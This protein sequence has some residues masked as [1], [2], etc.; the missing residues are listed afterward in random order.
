MIALLIAS[1]IDRL[2]STIPVVAFLDQEEDTFKYWLGGELLTG[3]PDTGSEINLMSLSF[4]ESRGFVIDQDIVYQA[5]FADSSVQRMEDSVQVPVSFGSNMNPSVLPRLVRL[6]IATS[7]SVHAP[8]DSAS[9]ILSHQRQLMPIPTV[10]GRSLSTPRPWYNIVLFFYTKQCQRHCNTRSFR[11]TSITSGP[12]LRQG[13][14][15][16]IT[17]YTKSR[18]CHWN[19]K[20]FRSTSISSRPIS[21]H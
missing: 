12:I 16:I 20:S 5:Q 3:T 14:R 11:S 18:P 7:F 1:K 17:P 6:P 2:K 9:G 10:S 4:A 19:T 21:R 8:R 13:P 15:Y